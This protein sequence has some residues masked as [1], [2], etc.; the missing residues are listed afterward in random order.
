LL[1][2]REGSLVRSKEVGQEGNADKAKYMFM[3][4]EQ[5]VGHNHDIKLSFKVVAQFGYLK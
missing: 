5:N 4:H 1:G 2:N 3:T